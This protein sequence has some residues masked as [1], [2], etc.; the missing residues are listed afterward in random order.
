MHSNIKILL[1]NNLQKNAELLLKEKEDVLKKE[2]EDTEIKLKELKD[3]S[4]IDQQNLTVE[5]TQT[6]NSF[7]K[8]IFEIRKELRAVQRELGENIKKLETI[9]KLINIWLMPFLVVIVFL[10]FK[11]FTI[12]KNKKYVNKIQSST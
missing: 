4:E 11:F 9:L 8:K 12:K 3:S 10:I 7:N 6:I 1:Q 5:Q 2:L